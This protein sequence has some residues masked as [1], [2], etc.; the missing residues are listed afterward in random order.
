[1]KDSRKEKGPETGWAWAYRIKGHKGEGSSWYLRSTDSVLL[2]EVRTDWISYTLLSH[3]PFYNSWYIFSTYWQM[4]YYQCPC[5]H[6]SRTFHEVPQ[7]RLLMVELLL[8]DDGGS[9][10]RYLALSGIGCRSDLED[11]PFSILR[12]PRVPLFRTF[13]Y[14]AYIY[15]YMYV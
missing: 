9:N 10:I 6:L 15:I 3:I 2:F 13:S 1:M 14:C 12:T 7:E 11:K 5:D 4:N 8:G